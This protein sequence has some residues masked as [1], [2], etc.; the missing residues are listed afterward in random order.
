[1]PRRLLDHGELIGDELE[2]VFRQADADNP[3]LAHPFKRKLIVL[4]RMFQDPSLAAGTSWP[5]EPEAVAAAAPVP[6]A[7]GET[8]DSR[9]DSRRWRPEQG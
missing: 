3:A 9:W 4:P 1:M 5:S 2:E 8:P 6:P 7:A